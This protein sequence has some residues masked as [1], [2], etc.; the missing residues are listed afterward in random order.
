[1]PQIDDV[2]D[3]F[4]KEMERVFIKLPKC[5]TKNLLGDFNAKVSREDIFKPTV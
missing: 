2:K 4:Y 5:H 1:M 3:S